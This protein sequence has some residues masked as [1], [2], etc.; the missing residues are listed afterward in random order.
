[1]KEII[2]AN[3]TNFDSILESNNLVLVDFWAPWCG[4]C[5]MQTPILEKIVKSDDI[6]AV[7]AKLN[8]DDSP[9]IAQKM[10]IA[11]IPTLILFKNKTEIDRFV[12]LQPEQVLKD[13]L[14]NS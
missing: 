1:M 7:I 13:K 9:D 6:N 5:K 10:G 4:P 3:S 14:I 8:T 11:S 2:E 12:G